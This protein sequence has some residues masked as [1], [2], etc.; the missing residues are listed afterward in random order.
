MAPVPASEAGVGRP[1]GS[2]YF[3]PASSVE[4]GQRWMTSVRLS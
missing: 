2:R 4:A 3:E 1:E